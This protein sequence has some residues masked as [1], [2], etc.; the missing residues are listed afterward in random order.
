[1]KYSIGLDF[2][3]LSGRALLVELETGREIATSVFEYPHAV[4][5]RQL[6]CGV[7]L[8]ADFALQHPQDYLDVLT[9]VIP[10]VL[11]QT[12]VSASDVVGV[13][14]DFT[15]CTVLPV[16]ED[17]TPL[18]FL[19]EFENRPHSYVK[20]WKH[21]AAQDQA[22]ILNAIAAERGEAWLKR[23]GGKISSEWIFPKIMET[24][25]KDEA[26]YDRAFRFVEGT[27]WLVW[28]LTGKETHSSGTAGYKA[29]WH[30]KNGFPSP[31]FFEKLDPR[32]K[33][34]I[35]TKISD[36]ITA[37]GSRAGEI[38]QKASQLTG[39]A[40]G[41]PVAIG[42]MDAHVALPAV[43]I[44]K[45]GKMLMIMGTSTC[46]IVMGE[47]EMDVPG[48][49]GV[50]EDG[51]VPGYFG[52]EAGQCC[53]GDHFAWFVKNCV[54]AEYTEQAEREGVSIHKVLREKAQKLKV[55]ESGLLAL[56][57]WNGNRSTLVDS[58]LTGMMLG[59]NLE[60]RP[61]EIYRALIEA[62]AYGTRIIIENYEEHGVP[63]HEL[64]AAGGIA[65]KD[66]MM[67]QIYADVTG[68]EIY[69]SGSSQAPALG[70]AMFG[71]VAG[72]YFPNMDECAKVLAKIKDTVYRPI[73]ENTRVYDKLY[74]EYKILYH[75]FGHENNCMK[76]LKKVRDNA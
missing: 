34:I 59:M 71:A 28:Q 55:G 57:F 35:G 38:S 30:K 26:V 27:D 60:T 33:N 21:H 41:T 76:R 3:T 36:K 46:H 64:Y 67:M 50:V 72:G 62:T 40:V 7:E 24:L 2:G 47:Q 22:D 1:M 73:P 11:A 70:S 44:T 12:S 48:I 56:D 63:I 43:G 17:G 13:G 18:C 8:P 31:E 66:E 65:A 23:Y 74:A 61:E 16:L 19:P 5:S 9:H 52:Y 45:P 49:C 53:C 69:L 51:V 75:Y 32:M 6:D 14:V 10:D 4:M 58:D 15:A 42:N 54:P 68:K 29:I 25:K 39:L 37:L 20:L